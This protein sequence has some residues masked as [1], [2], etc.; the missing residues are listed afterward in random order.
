M[1]TKRESYDNEI[2]NLRAFYLVLLKKIW[3]IPALTIM[4]AVVAGIIYFLSNVVYAPAR[5]Y[6]TESTLYIYFAYDENKGSEVDAYNAYTWNLLVKA[7]FEGLKGIID[8]T[9]ENN[10]LDGIMKNLEENGYKEGSNITRDEVIASINADIPSDVRVMVVTVKN[11]DRELSGAIADATNAALINYGNSDSAFNQIKL[12]GRT[13]TK[14]ELLPDRMGVAVIFGA[15]LGFVFAFLG[16]LFGKAMDDAVYVPEDVEKRYGIP[17][18]GVVS[19]E[20]A[21]EP[22]FLRNELL[23]T[24]KEKLKNERNIAV[25]SADDKKGSKN[26]DEAVLR[27]TE[28]IG[29]GLPEGMP[30]LK[31]MALPGNDNESLEKLSHVD[32]AIIAIRMGD[33]NGA[34]TGHLISLLK[35]LDCRVLGIVITDA[36]INLLERYLGL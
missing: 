8:E 3:I 21:K 20:G 11:P 5:N 32:G 17:V 22:A 2:L 16:L 19:S 28:V 13:D 14:I 7:D 18:L 27:L 31:A 30:S 23:F 35:K 4:G 24:F 9:R 12:I 34:M 36:D 10:I 25:I 26:A 33:H 6:V 1:T 29:K 15:V